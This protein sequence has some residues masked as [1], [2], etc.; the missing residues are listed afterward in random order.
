MRQHGRAVSELQI[1]CDIWSNTCLD[2][3][4][5]LLKDKICIYIR[6]LNK[7]DCPLQMCR[8]HAIN[9]KLREKEQSCLKKK[10]V[11]LQIDSRLNLQY[12]LF[13]GSTANEVCT[14]D[15]KL[16]KMGPISSNNSSLLIVFIYVYSIDFFKKEILT[17][18]QSQY[19][20]CMW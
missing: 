4:E 9:Q 20:V 1:I 12:L 5:V 2:I 7:A 14:T 11:F 13:P 19:S 18:M 16:G 3:M 10:Q 6:T 15:S 8:F 17:K